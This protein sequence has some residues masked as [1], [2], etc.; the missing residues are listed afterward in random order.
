[1]KCLRKE[2]S[3]RYASAGELADELRRWL[4]GEPIQAR[5]P[6]KL[7]RWTRTVRRRKEWL[8]LAGGAL[9]ALAGIVSLF[10]FLRPSP[11][12]AAG[13]AQATDKPEPPSKPSPSR[14]DDT[15]DRVRLVARRTRT[16]NNFKQLGIAMRSMSDVYQCLPPA[17]IADRR[18]GQPL[19]S[20]R[21]AVLPFIEQAELYKPLQAR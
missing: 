8:Y 19:L 4:D 16:A 7:R 9:L 20:W 17:A 1:M 15:I 3:Q 14:K 2:P 11:N 5:P 21:V 18:T 13:V 10:V 6:G 12:A